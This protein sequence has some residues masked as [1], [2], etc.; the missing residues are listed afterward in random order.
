MDD[1]PHQDLAGDHQGHLTVPKADHLHHPRVHK[2]VNISAEDQEEEATS[3]LVAEAP[4]EDL[5]EETTTEDNKV[6]L[7]RA[8]TKSLLEDHQG[9]VAVDNMTRDH[10][11]EDLPQNHQDLLLTPVPLLE[12]APPAIIHSLLAQED[13]V[14]NTEA[15][16]VEDHSEDPV[17]S[18][19]EEAHLHP[20]VLADLH[21][22]DNA[23]FFLDYVVPVSL[24]LR[25]N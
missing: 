19:E 22:G 14:V 15:E 21:T 2:E 10:L 11:V 8:A 13:P 16:V 17:A 20:K 25:I 7:K 24:H 9:V 4:E 3:E 12:E 23:K 1:H 5:K 18:T 6:H